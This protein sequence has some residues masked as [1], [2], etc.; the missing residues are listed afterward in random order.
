MALE[1]SWA[2][3]WES[4]HKRCWKNCRIAEF[5]AGTKSIANLWQS[6]C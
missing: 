2:G 6:G 5:V 4:N 1:G 3:Q